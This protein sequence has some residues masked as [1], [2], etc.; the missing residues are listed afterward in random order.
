MLKLLLYTFPAIVNYILGG[1]NFIC[2]Y[3]FSEARA[4]GW[5]VGASLSM[6]AGIYLAVSLLLVRFV[7]ARN[8]GR[9]ICTGGVV[10]ALSSLGFIV[11]D[12]L[13]TQFVWIAASGVGSAIY[14]TPFQVFS[15]SLGAGAEGGIRAATANYTVSWSLGYAAG[16]FL[17]GVL[18][19]VTAYFCNFALSVVLAVGILAIDRRC[20]PP[21][22][23]RGEPA[24]CTT[25]GKGRQ[26]R[27]LLPL[28]GDGMLVWLGWS[29]GF[30]GVVANMIVRS[31]VPFRGTL[32]EIPR[33]RL[34]FVMALIPAVQALCA[35]CLRFFPTLPYRRPPMLA[36]SLCGILSMG[37]FGCGGSFEVF[38]AASLLF[39]IY[40]GFF[41]FLYVFHSM[42]HPTRSTVSLGVNEAL[43]G[44][45]GVFGPIAGGLLTSPAASGRAF[46]VF[47]VPIAVAAAWG[48]FLIGRHF[49]RLK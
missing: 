15:R 46:V 19:P 48:S 22:E 40:A 37:L 47:L 14:C 33:D 43:V 26:E 27:E 29:V 1:M 35:G 16:P 41:Y 34:G 2:A 32:L 7:T 20:R 45:A 18:S 25:S 4:P 39:G 3:R 36:A 24:C 44:F 49:S 10:L 13:L 23:T 6:W 42:A 9:L 30:A 8:A 31:L 28:T 5:M 38:L 21:E 17:F 12:G 11:F